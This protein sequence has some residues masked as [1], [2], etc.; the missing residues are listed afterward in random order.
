RRDAAAVRLLETAGAVAIG[1]T[2]MDPLGWSTHGQA[3]G[4]PPCRNPIDPRLSPGGSS[5][6][7]AVAV[8]AGI[9][10]L[11][12]GT[13]TA[14]SLRIPAAFCG[15]V[16]LKPASDQVPAE[17]CLPLAPSFDTIGV[18]GRSVRDCAA[19]H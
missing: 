19:A 14:G 2:A 4:F 17:G 8:A 1:K 11:G 12:L 16:A 9:V 15:I 10:P 3:E 7:S 6:G 13:D 5:S 18:L